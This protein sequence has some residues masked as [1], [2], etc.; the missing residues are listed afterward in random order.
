MLS[1]ISNDRAGPEQDQQ[2]QGGPSSSDRAGEPPGV[3]QYEL[4]A[5]CSKASVKPEWA[6]PVVTLTQVEARS[7]ASSSVNSAQP[8]VRPA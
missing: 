2:R 5:A 8:A 3:Q 1:R 6:C 4:N 7:E